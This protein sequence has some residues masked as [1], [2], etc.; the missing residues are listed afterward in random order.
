MSHP[1]QMAFFGDVVAAFPAHFAGRV[2]DVGSADVNG[3]P[4]LLLDE[5]SRYVGVDLA[6]HANVDV[7]ADAATLA[8]RAGWFDVTMSSECFEHAERWPDIL[9]NMVRMTRPGGLVVFSAAGTGR[10]E[11]GT[12]RSHDGGRASPGTSTRGDDWYRN[13]TEH[14]ARRAL[15]RSGVTV[16][17]LHLDRRVSDLYAVG[18]VAPVRPDDRRRLDDIVRSLRGRPGPNRWPRSRA[19]NLVLRATG[20]RGM[21]VVARWRN[22]RDR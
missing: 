22:R 16:D 3:G 14:E 13:V 19:G 11:H 21:A 18:L 6:P 15:R 1:A 10:G 17:A 12:S 5:P 20:D 2:L 9:A 4:H 8:F 7:V